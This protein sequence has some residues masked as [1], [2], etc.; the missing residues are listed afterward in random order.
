MLTRKKTVKL[1]IRNDKLR[2]QLAVLI[3][4]M[5]GFLIQRVDDT[6][7]SDLLILEISDDTAQD[8]DYLNRA[9]ATGKARDFFITSKSTNPDVLIQALRMGVKEFI[10]QPVNEAE[11]RKALVRFR[12][13]SEAAAAVSKGPQRKGQIIDLLGVKGGVGTTTIAVNL[14]D[15][16]VRLEGK[17][18]VAIIDMNRLF[19][20]IPLFLSLEHVFNW[21]DV[22]KNITRLDATYLTGILYQHRSG[23]RVLPSPDRVDDSYTVTPQVIESLLR[24]MRQMFDYVIIDSGQAVDDISKMILR[25]ADKVLLVSGLSLPCLINVKKLLKIFRDL[26]YPPEPWVEVVFNRFDRKSI[27]SL[28]EAEQSTGKKPFWVVPNDFN[29]TMNAI[30][31]GK[32]LSMVEPGA[33]VTQAIEDMA[34]ALTGRST[35]SG[36]DK[37]KRAFLGLKLF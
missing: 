18:S 1:E 29:A 3:G 8:F 34:A 16:L 15:S 6:M 10:P 22:S 21:V 5:E 2:E 20:E 30:N 13:G 11:L 4:S 31:Q 17:L 25:S 12:D 14:A 27:I 32:P 26:G 24:L 36:R 33:E 19:G 35:G 28:R 7:P 23:L 9:R 37:D